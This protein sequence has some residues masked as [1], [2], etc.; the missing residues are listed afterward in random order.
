MARRADFGSSHKYACQICGQS[1][2]NKATCETGWTALQ[3]ERS[4][5]H[6]CQDCGLYK[7]NYGLKVGL[8]RIVALCDCSLTS[9][10]NR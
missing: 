1:G 7:A 6:L 8:G 2:H 4:K 3:R 5:E 9:Y 10:Y